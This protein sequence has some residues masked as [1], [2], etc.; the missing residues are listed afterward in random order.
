MN[1]RISIPA[2]L[3]LL[4]FITA[5]LLNAQIVTIPIETKNNTQ[6]DR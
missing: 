5:G 4:L 6:T 3:T 2:L 1:K